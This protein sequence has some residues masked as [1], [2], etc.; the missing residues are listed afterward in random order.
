MEKNGVPG[1]PP[2]DK[3]VEPDSYAE[4]A[5]EAPS[6]TAKNGFITRFL[7]GCKGPTGLTPVGKETSISDAAAHPETTNGSRAHGCPPRR[8]KNYLGL[9][10]RT[11]LLILLG[12]VVCVAALA[13]GLGLGLGLKKSSSTSLPLPS[14]TDTLTGD[15]T[16]YAPA[17][18]ACGVTSAA[19]DLI[20]A[21]SH[22]L[23]DAASTSSDPNQN[24]LCG[25]KIRVE[26]YDESAQR[27]RTVD[28]TVV[29]RCVGCKVDDLD[30]SPTS[31][32]HLADEDL[33]RVTGTWAW[34]S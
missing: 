13:L 27:N 30:L 16:F 6:A 17:L 31:F 26:R 1:M 12:L 4:P 22:I 5:W 20:C 33:G 18:G 7:R 8:H 2:L 28:V 9:S 32:D 3:R 14:N 15:L 29:D 11:F 19:T 10:R 24:P 23:F 25:R 34:L 21:V